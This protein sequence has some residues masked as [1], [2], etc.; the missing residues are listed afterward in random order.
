MFRRS[1]KGL[2]FGTLFVDSD[3]VLVNSHLSAGYMGLLAVRSDGIEVK[4]SSDGMPCMA[5]GWVVLMLVVA[6]LWQQLLCS[7][8]WLHL[9]NLMNK[10]F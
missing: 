3:M 4:R 8:G 2:D 1:I 6:G 9:G 7:D 10:L 5:G